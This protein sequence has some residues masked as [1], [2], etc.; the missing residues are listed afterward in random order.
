MRCDAIREAISAGLDGEAA[1]LDPPAI[2]AH[3]RDCAACAA[4][5]DD[6]TTVHRAVRVRAAE[7]VPDLSAAILGHPPAARARWREVWAEPISAARWGLFAVALTQLLLAAPALVLGDDAGATVH[8]AREMGSFDVA[9]GIGL[10]VAAWQ[11]A[12][13]WGLLPVAAVLA[14]VMG[15]TAAVDLVRGSVSSLNEAH[16]VL[17][18]AGVTLLWLVA[19]E[20]ASPGP[21]R[22]GGGLARS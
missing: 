15:G 17:D 18:I 8:V 22:R 20:A 2:D 9:L 3:T 11:P 14:L 6:A 16:H 7:P 1:G 10:L 21:A 5:A 19:R 4:W 13:A 12:R